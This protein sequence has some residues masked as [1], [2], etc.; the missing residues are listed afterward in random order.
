[1][2]RTTETQEMEG[3]GMSIGEIA[4]K[5]ADLHQKIDRL[6][7]LTQ[8]LTP[9]EREIDKKLTSRMARDYARLGVK[10]TKAILNDVN[11]VSAQCQA[12]INYLESYLES[13]SITNDNEKQE[14]AEEMRQALDYLA[15]VAATGE[16]DQ[17]TFAS[18]SK[19]IFA[20]YSTSTAK[21]DGLT[22]EEVKACRSEERR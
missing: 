9:E 11:E 6:P 15:K 12:R 1:M 4:A 14:R 2:P 21:I 22:S 7:D 17:K 16:I 20:R 13:Q 19:E 3:Q 8:F 5:I 10:S 18:Q